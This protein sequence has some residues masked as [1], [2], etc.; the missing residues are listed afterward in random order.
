MEKSEKKFGP[1]ALLLDHHSRAP[2]A[3]GGQFEQLE[4]TNPL[5]TVEETVPGADASLPERGPRQDV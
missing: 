4:F 1:T 2:N 5:Q 3:D